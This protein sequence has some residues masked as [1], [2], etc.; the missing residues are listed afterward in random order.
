M[1]EY[2]ISI[3]DNHPL[4]LEGMAALVRRKPG[5]T[6]SAMG[7]TVGHIRSIATD[8]RPDAMILDFNMPGDAFR[9]LLEVLSG[10]PAMKVLVFT[11]SSDT[12]LA[13]ALLDAGVSGF[14]LKSSST[15]ELCTAID[16]IRRDEVFISPSFAA[17]IIGALK[18]KPAN[19]RP[20][21]MPNFSAREHQ[22][23]RLLSSGKRNR[24]IASALSL[25]ERTVKGYMTLLMQKLR[26]RN[27]L[28][29]VIAVQGL[30]QAATLRGDIENDT[31][32]GPFG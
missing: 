25:S 4:L 24:E 30:S 18:H 10:W 29:A 16:A 3:I 26:A 22:I 15:D 19:T 1:A 5:L 32:S 17:R 12:N 8:H 28:E 7:S 11:A 23:V 21:P 2:R 14:V 9:A 13:I 27:R 20:T 31:L 6:L